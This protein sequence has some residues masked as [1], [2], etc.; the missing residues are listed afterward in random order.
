G[1]RILR[2]SDD[3]AGFSKVTSLRA[4]LQDSLQ[5][6]K[7][8]DASKGPLNVADQTMASITSLVQEARTLAVGQAGAPADAATRAATATQVARIRE[9]ILELA[10][11]QVGGRHIFAG[12]AVTTRPFGADGAYLGNGEN[13]K[14]NLGIATPIAL[15]VVGSEFL[16]TDLDPDLFQTAS[17]VKSTTPLTDRF[18]INASNNVLVIQEFPSGTSFNVALNAGTYT[19]DQL[20][21]ELQSQLTNFTPVGGTYAVTYDESTDR[22]RIQ[23]TGGLASE[24]RVISAGTNPAST[25]AAVFGFNADSAQKSEAVSGTETAFN[26]IAGVNDSFSIQVDGGTSTA[27]TVD[28]GVYT[29]QTLASQ[30]QLRVNNNVKR[31]TASNNTI[32]ILEDGG[33]RSAT[34]TVPAGTKTGATLAADLQAA[35]N[36]STVLKGSTAA[37]PPGPGYVVTYTAGADKFTITTATP[38]T[39]PPANLAVDVS[40]PDGLAALMGFTVPVPFASTVTS[41]KNITG[42]KVDY[43]VSFKDTFT[44]TSPTVGAG[45]SVSIGAGANNIL[46]A[47]NLNGATA[48]ASRSTLLSDL[49]KGKG[50]AAGT[51]S[52]TNRAGQT[53]TVDLSTAATLNDVFAKIEAAVTGVKASLAADG[54]RIVLTDSN[55]PRVSNLIVREVGTTT[56]AAGLGIKADVPGNITGLDVGPSV[57]ASTLVSA[58]RGGR[59]IN[60]G[61]VRIGTA[62]IDLAIGKEA[63]VGDILSAINSQSGSGAKASISSDGSHLRLASTN[64]V[65]S[66][67]ITDITASAAKE[68]GFQGADNVLGLL[69][70]L[71]EALRRNDG[72]TL[73][74][75]LDAFSEA[76]ER[77]GLARVKIGQVSQQFD[78]FKAQQEEVEVSF[79]EVLSSVEDADIVEAM[80]QFSIFQN[81]LQ[82]ALAS[83]AQILQVQ[84]LDFLR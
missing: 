58:L 21:A 49:N 12:T 75:T 31:V 6:R 55:S 72:E 56:T 66:A 57:S 7:N 82:A 3:P 25:A 44:I 9:S 63:T 47:L 45:S 18:T 42:A 73:G 70:T 28:A 30:I 38:G 33:V 59:G 54:K 52:I 1:K 2:P 43:G 17:H 29:A 22:F 13:L 53:F 51:I 74:K 16:T 79:T 11:T 19:G 60:L 15:N 20:A 39:P 76:L 8:I 32:R 68:L 24:F 50:V 84:L 10:N 34:L 64:P 78:R 46:P 62:T 40:S 80:T 48:T 71:E 27:V 65:K 5:V 77:I 83:S 35:L 4:L 61:T 67:L 26:V 41:D 81:T 36:A 69:D 23:V 37:T 14:I